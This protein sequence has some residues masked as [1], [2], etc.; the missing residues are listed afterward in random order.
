MA[1][2]RIIGL[3]LKKAELKLKAE[4]VS[5]ETRAKADAVKFEADIKAGIKK[6]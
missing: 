6:L 4:V 5:L 1:I 3:W 2:F